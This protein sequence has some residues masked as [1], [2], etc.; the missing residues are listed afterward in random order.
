MYFH[1]KVHPFTTGKTVLRVLYNKH[2]FFSVSGT[3]KEGCT[4]SVYNLLT[5]YGS[6][7]APILFFRNLQHT[8]NNYNIIKNSIYKHYHQVKH[9]KA[10]YHYH[11]MLN[12]QQHLHNH[13]DQNYH[14]AYHLSQNNNESS[15]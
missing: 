8:V 5:R 9:Y 6:I 11:N 1:S 4:H 13:L 10:Q 12:Y 2:S 15:C 14:T 7:I 3:S